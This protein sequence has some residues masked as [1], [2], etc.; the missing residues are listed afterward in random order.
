MPSPA[1]VSD[2]I[3]ATGDRRRDVTDHTAASEAG[4]SDMKDESGRNLHDSLR[5]NRN[6]LYC[7]HEF[8]PPSK[9]TSHSEAPR[10]R[11]RAL[12]RWYFD[13]VTV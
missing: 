8:S 10:K 4:G 7:V 1:Q 5:I 3:V 11:G 12:H 9:L 6:V 2:N 13:P